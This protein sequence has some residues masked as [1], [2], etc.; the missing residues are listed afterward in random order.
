MNNGIKD[1]GFSLGSKIVSIVFALGV[2]LCLAWFLGTEGRGSYAVC[3]LFAAMLSM[4]FLMGC[5]LA[6]VYFVSFKRFS[7]SE[8]VINTV[9]YGG[10]GSVLAIAAGLVLMQFPLAFFDKANKPELYLALVSIPLFLCSMVFTQLFTAIR[11]F[12]WFSAMTLLRCICLF[13]FTI[14]FL[15][16]FHWGVPGA[17]LAIITSNMIVVLACLAAFRM[18]FGLAADWPRIKDL[19]TML[20]YGVRYSVGVISNQMNFRVGTLIL[21]F[22]ATRDE[23]GI[24]A[25]AVGLTIQMQILPDAVKTVLIPRAASDE[26]GR[27]DL[28]AHCARLTA[29]VSL[30]MLLGFMLLAKPIVAV[31]FPDSFAS[32]G[33]LMQIL[34][35]GF[36][37]RTLGKSLES[38]LIGCNRPGIVSLSVALGMVVNVG[39]LFLLLPRMGLAGAAWSL[40]FN[41][42]LSSLILIASFSRLTGMGPL[43]VWRPRSSDFTFLS[44]LRARFIPRKTREERNAWSMQ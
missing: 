44:G 30:L 8:G 26:R 35:F 19:L 22:F 29:L 15:G 32:A 7:L 5:E 25:F 18:K 33:L 37:L 28:V 34:A 41:Y 1:L 40:V 27:K 6:G 16:G 17:M 13:V 3:I 43:S 24:Y 4:V 10:I 12:G 23:I 21:A 36:F 38:Y 11:Q 9:V 39:T 31:F 42:L 14:L 20:H 2:Q